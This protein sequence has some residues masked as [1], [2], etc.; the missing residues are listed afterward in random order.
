MNVWRLCGE[1]QLSNEKKPSCLGYIGDY[2][3]QLNGDHNTFKIIR[4]IPSKQPGFNGKEDFL[5]WLNCNLAPTSHLAIWQNTANILRFRSQVHDLDRSNLQE[6]PQARLNLAAKCWTKTLWLRIISREFALQ[7]PFKILH[8]PTGDK[9]YLKWYACTVMHANPA[10]LTIAS[11]A[12]LMGESSLVSSPNC[13]RPQIDECRQCRS[14]F[15]TTVSFWMIGVACTFQANTDSF[16]YLPCYW[17]QVYWVQKTI[18][19][20]V[21]ICLYN[22]VLRK[23]PWVLRHCISAWL[24]NFDGQEA[25]DKR[26]P[27][28]PSFLSSKQ[29]N[30]SSCF[31]KHR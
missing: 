20:T 31:A 3:T 22:G 24:L 13:N 26:G 30:R 12:W 27:S 15:Q 25:Q 28:A 7:E 29:R 14:T 9:G 19:E 21:Y 23:V 6:W 16:F 8:Q 5:S 4:R 2:T 11:S 18:S 10:V 17:I 1:T